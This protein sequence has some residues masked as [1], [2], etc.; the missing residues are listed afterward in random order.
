M[1]SLPQLLDERHQVRLVFVH[2][3]SALGR[4]LLSIFGNERHHSR[5]DFQRNGH[6]FGSAGHFEVEM[7]G[8]N[9]FEQ[10]DIAILDVASVFTQVGCDP[11]CAGESLL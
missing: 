3:K 9:L 10:P 6:H 8:N 1:P 5:H 2:G 7:S 11:A 4:P